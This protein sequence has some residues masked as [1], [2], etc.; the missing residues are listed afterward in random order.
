M[1]CAKEVAS[2]Q[3]LRFKQRKMKVTKS[4]IGML[5]MLNQKEIW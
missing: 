5:K 3:Y 1:K 4:K 2:K